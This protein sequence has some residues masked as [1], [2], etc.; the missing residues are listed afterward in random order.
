VV[1]DVAQ[2]GQAGQ[3]PKIESDAAGVRPGVAVLAGRPP[4]RLGFRV[5]R[6]R[7]N[8]GGGGG[9]GAATSSCSGCGGRRRRASDGIARRHGEARKKQSFST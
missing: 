8:V 3:L 4:R 2:Q 7:R 6:R 5:R 9:R 1:V